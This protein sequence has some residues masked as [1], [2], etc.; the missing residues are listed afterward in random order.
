[1]KRTFFTI[2]LALVYLT[3]LA[4]DADTCKLIAEHI[5]TAAQ[6]HK[7]DGIEELLASD[8]HFNNIKQP[9]AAKVLKQIIAQMPTMMSWELLTPNRTARG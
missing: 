6:N 8:F 3:G 7:P 9:L 5:L 1:M 2:L 4:Q